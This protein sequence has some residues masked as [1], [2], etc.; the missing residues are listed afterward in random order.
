MVQNFYEFLAI[1]WKVFSE[2]LE[3]FIAVFVLFLAYRLL[4]LGMKQVQ[5]TN[6][7]IDAK[8]YFMLLAP[9]A[10]FAVGG[11]VLALGR[12]VFLSHHFETTIAAFVLFLGFI[13]IR[14]GLELAAPTISNENIASYL[15]YLAP[16][17]AFALIGIVFVMGRDPSSL[18]IY[19]L[20][21]TVAIGFGFAALGYRLFSK[22]VLGD[23]DLEAEWKD[24]KILLR[25]AAPG[26]LFAL[27][28]LTMIGVALWQG[29][30]ILREYHT[31][32]R[33]IRQR[34][35]SADKYQWQV[36][37]QVLNE[38]LEVLR[39]HFELQQSNTELESSLPS[40]MNEEQDST[41]NR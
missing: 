10:G 40:N 36:I 32:D 14:R 28:G 23:S 18:M 39:Q 5:M 11:I 38:G 1:L 35:I 41:M 24:R 6:D 20:S 29:P 25:R 31:T 21:L 33:Q 13:L 12:E 8:K 37:D 16:G 19:L 9:G 26:T 17:A 22:G 30:D 3:T 15:K 4:R 34:Q 27:F 2:H 7:V